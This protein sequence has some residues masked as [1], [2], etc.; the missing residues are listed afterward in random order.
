[1]WLI[2]Y[3]ITALACCTVLSVV[4]VGGGWRWNSGITQMRGSLNV[5]GRSFLL[6]GF[7]LSSNEMN[8]LVPLTPV[9]VSTQLLRPIISDAGLSQG[10]R[11]KEV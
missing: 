1:M 5:I 2:Y 9:Q 4:R 3:C 11:T 8:H 6:V 10:K 7:L